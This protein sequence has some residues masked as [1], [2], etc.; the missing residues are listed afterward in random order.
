MLLDKPLLH[1]HADDTSDSKTGDIQHS[2]N[3]TAIAISRSTARLQKAD[4]AM[5][6]YD[7]ALLINRDIVKRARQLLARIHST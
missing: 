3:A 2:L 1:N 4:A 7:A 5:R 6:H